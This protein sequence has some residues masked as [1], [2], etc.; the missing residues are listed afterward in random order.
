MK[1]A[2]IAIRQRY[3]ALEIEI[4]T[5]GD[6]ERAAKDS[7]PIDEN[8]MKSFSKVTLHRYYFE[9]LIANRTNLIEAR[10][11]RYHSPFPTSYSSAF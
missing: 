9:S 1:E 11:P 6:R 2:E 8:L 5:G 10:D 7:L 3:S 4:K